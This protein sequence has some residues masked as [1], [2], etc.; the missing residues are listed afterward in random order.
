MGGSSGVAE[1][2]F[3]DEDLRRRLGDDPELMA[4]AMQMFLA[5]APGRV[6]QMRA[7]AAGGDYESLR[8]LAHS[9]RGVALTISAP[10]LARLTTELEQQTREARPDG[11]SER[12]S[13]IEEEYAC[14]RQAVAFRVGQQR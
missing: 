2:H 12:I 4:D 14:V 3:D 9:L 5:G 10:R 13:D 11:L 8:K 1:T 7:A 6:E